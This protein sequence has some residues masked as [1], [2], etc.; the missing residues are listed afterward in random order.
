MSTDTDSDSLDPDPEKFRNLG[1]QVMDM[2]AD[3]FEGVREVDTFPDTTPPEVAA[4]F[5]EPLPEEGQD[6]MDV[7][8]E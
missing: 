2:I 1:Y 6:A 8:A 5:D 3:H 7:L 4:V